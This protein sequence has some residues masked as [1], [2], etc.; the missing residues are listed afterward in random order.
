MSINKLAFGGGCH[1]C[2]EAV[3]QSLVGVESVH[4]GWATHIESDNGFSEAALIEYTPEIIELDVLIEVHLLTHSSTSNHSMRNKYRSAIYVTH[5]EQ[6]RNVTEVLASLKG[7]F[8]EPLQTQILPLVG[9]KSNPKYQNYYYQNPNRTFCRRYINPKLLL[10]LER[11]P[12]KVKRDKV[13]AA[14]SEDG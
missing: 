11:F 3:F 13:N 4:Q 6:E 8:S 12:E 2:T 14:L 7:N 5:A 9:F 10:M 1:W